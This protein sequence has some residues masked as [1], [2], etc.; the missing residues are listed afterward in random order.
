MAAA[1]LKTIA[2]LYFPS[3]RP[4]LRSVAIAPP[5]RSTQAPKAGAI[6]PDPHPH[7]SEFGNPYSSICC[8]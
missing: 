5:V 6:A 1:I 3:S 2:Q 4:L 7:P 8:L